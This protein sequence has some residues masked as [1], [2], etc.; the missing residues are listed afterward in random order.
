M[1]VSLLNT[2]KSLCG[3]HGGRSSRV[4][5][6]LGVELGPVWPDELRQPGRYGFQ[7]P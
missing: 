1:S 4:A 3:F 7:G 2:L 6:G 5:D